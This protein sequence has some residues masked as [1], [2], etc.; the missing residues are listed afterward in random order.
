MQKLYILREKYFIITNCN[1]FSLRIIIG[2]LQQNYYFF[3]D[4]NNNHFYKH[5]F[6]SN[7]CPEFLAIITHRKIYKYC[8]V[9]IHWLNDFFLTSR[10]FNHNL[11][12]FL[13]LVSNLSTSYCRRILSSFFTRHSPKRAMHF[14][15][16]FPFIYCWRRAHAIHPMGAGHR[17]C[18]VSYV[19]GHTH[20]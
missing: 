12:F 5:I 15:Y 2:S 7:Y 3:Y 9:Y 18:D 11:F 1:N 8:K 19:L 20:P 17:S 13:S 10:N 4:N 16:W 14:V 6:R